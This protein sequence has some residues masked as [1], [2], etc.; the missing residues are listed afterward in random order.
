MYQHQDI[1]L[2]YIKNVTLD[3]V[4]INVFGCTSHVPCVNSYKLENIY[5][6]NASNF[7]AYKAYNIELNSWL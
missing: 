7:M 1:F 6:T 3:S 5:A 2:G 4:T